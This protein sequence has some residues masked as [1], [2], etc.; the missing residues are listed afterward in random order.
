MMIVDENDGKV[1]G[2]LPNTKGIHGMALAQD[3]GKGFT[4]NGQANTV[5]VFDLKSMKFLS[6]IKISGDDQDSIL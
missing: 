3:L 6:E 4:S 2:D 5:T 1:I